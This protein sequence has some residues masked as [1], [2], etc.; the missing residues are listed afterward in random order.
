M[1]HKIAGRSINNF[2]YADDATLMAEREEEPDI[3]LPM[4][5]GSYKKQEISRTIS[6]L[7]TTL[8]PLCEL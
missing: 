1:N 3:K 2:K 4:S 5:V 7:L 6:T 8:K